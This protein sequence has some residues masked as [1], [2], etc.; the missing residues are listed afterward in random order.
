MVLLGSSDNPE[1][2]VPLCGHA[3]SVCAGDINCGPSK[4]Q[5]RFWPGYTFTS[6]R[7]APPPRRRRGLLHVALGDYTAVRLAR[8]L[9]S[10][11]RLAALARGNLR[12]LL[13]P[14]LVN[15]FEAPLGAAA[16]GADGSASDDD[17]D[18]VRVRGGQDAQRDPTA[19]L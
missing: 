6:G 15:R 8:P 18:G 5:A 2:E 10:L 7:D 4:K 19:A 17:E 1:G 13:T 16:R 12:G 3:V 9:V 14:A 11:R